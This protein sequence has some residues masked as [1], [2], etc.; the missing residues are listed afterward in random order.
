M[1]IKSS[2]E[3]VSFIFTEE[4]KKI[5]LEKGEFLYPWEIYTKFVG[6]LVFIDA[7][8]QERKLKNDKRS[9]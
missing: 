6:M 3:G 8:N 9:L 7:E 4:D 1:E 2:E 5:V